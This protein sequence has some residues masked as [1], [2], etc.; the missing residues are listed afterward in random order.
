[1]VH[2]VHAFREGVGVPSHTYSQPDMV[3][4]PTACILFCPYIK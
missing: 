1:M 3:A 4:L 2:M